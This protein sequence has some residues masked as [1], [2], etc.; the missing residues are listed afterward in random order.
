M[1][2]GKILHDHLREM[3]ED[4]PFRGI[5]LEVQ[6]VG[7]DASA[8]WNFFDESWSYRRLFSRSII[9]LSLPFHGRYTP[10]GGLVIFDVFVAGPGGK[11][12]A[13]RFGLFHG[14]NSLELPGRDTTSVEDCGQFSGPTDWLYKSLKNKD[15]SLEKYCKCRRNCPV[16][17]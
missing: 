3:I 9:D 7:G 17:G 13:H 4:L 2:V 12:V 8:V 15:L 6:A 5:F 11:R 1:G 10:A 14:G 16:V